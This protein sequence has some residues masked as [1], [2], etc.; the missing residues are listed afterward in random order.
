M[1]KKTLIIILSVIILIVACIAIYAFIMLNKINKKALIKTNADLGISAEMKQEEN[2]Q[3]DIVNIAFFG[4]DRLN[5]DV[6]SRSDSIM[7][8]S[9][10]S[11]NKEV[12][13]TSLMR[14]MYVM[15]PGMYETRINAAY[16]FGGP[17]L[18]LKT[19]N[20]DF[21]LDIKNYVTVDFFGLEKLIDKVGGVQIDVKE[22][23]ISNLN[24]NL[25]QVA[26]IEREKNPV[27]VKDPGLQT[28]NGRQA[29]AY[30]RI[31]HV[32]NSDYERTERQRTVLNGLFKKIK[33]QGIL[34]LPGTVMTILPYVETSLSSPEIINL[35]L[36]AI[37]FKTDNIEQYRL[38][39]DGYYNSERIRGM[40]VL[41]PNMDENK[42]LLHTFIYGTAQ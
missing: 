27:F 39:V 20:S 2:K 29:V 5:P 1:K 16:A 11:K 15:I 8:V 12:K 24:G 14:D 3:S 36:Q 30:S 40:D 10:D 13:V 19:I 31:R 33:S 4:L 41:V 21:D 32:G 38:P 35:A 7:V 25:S 22:D 42:K 18:A 34:R 17:Q 37:R 26:K 9:L 28:L 23:E 6:A